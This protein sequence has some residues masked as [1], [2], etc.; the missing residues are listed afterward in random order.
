[1]RPTALPGTAM[2]SAEEEAL[3]MEAG[4]TSAG[5]PPGPVAVSHTHTA[6]QP[7]K[8]APDAEDERPICPNQLLDIDRLLTKPDGRPTLAFKL[9]LLSSLPLPIMFCSTGTFLFPAVHGMWKGGDLREVVCGIGFVLLILSQPLNMFVVRRVCRPQ[10]LASI[11]IGRDRISRAQ[12]KGLEKA[13]Q[14]FH[15]FSPRCFVHPLQNLPQLILVSWICVWE[16]RGASES[17]TINRIS[18]VFF[19]QMT[20]CSACLFQATSTLALKAA[21]VLAANKISALAAALKTY[22]HKQSF[23]DQSSAGMFFN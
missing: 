3:V 20:I 11:G 6:A 5:G 8:S 2:M 19:V 22:V 14:T 9:L 18:G 17:A 21:C 12:Y 15:A 7:G 13:R 4:E 23:L 16:G 10:L 1:M